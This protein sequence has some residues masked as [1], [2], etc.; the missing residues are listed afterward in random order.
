MLNEDDKIFQCSSPARSTLENSREQDVIIDD[1]P[2]H[3]LQRAR[4][5]L[6]LSESDVAEALKLSVSRL[7]SIEADDFAPFASAIYVRGYLKNYC[8]LL[9]YDEQRV[10]D[11]YARFSQHQLPAEEEMRLE[12]IRAIS[13]EEV[14]HHSWLVYVVLFAIIL[15][16]LLSSWLLDSHDAPVV[17]E[18][19]S[20]IEQK[21]IADAMISIHEPMLID[22]PLLEHTRGVASLTASGDQIDDNQINDNQIDDD[23]ADNRVDQVSIETTVLSQGDE[24]QTDNDEQT[25]VVSRLTAAELAQTFQSTAQE[26]ASD[27]V[28]AVVLGDTLAFAFTQ[29]SWIQVIAADGKVLFKGLSKAGAELVVNGQAPFDIVVGN[30]EGTSLLFNDKPVELTTAN[31]RKTRRL[32][33]GN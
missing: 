6:G 5:Q 17:S 27:Q 32:T 33:L 3:L 15:L 14:K 9:K 10:M 23:L 21:G 22:L 28:S 24:T 11:A 18:L 30:V 16:W 31:G 25:L 12:P 7:Q 20:S 19:D 26:T 1:S 13:V 8:R 4:Q 2:G 29:E